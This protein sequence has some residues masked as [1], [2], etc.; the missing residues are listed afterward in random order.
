MQGVVGPKVASNGVL[1][2]IHGIDWGP[3][4]G[5]HRQT[6]NTGVVRAGLPS[7]S[8]ADCAGGHAWFRN[9]FASKLQ[10]LTGIEVD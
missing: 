8:Q 3:C 7:R 10:S 5:L 6:T 9:S 2:G 1:L 4:Y